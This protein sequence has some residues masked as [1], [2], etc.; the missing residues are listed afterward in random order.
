MVADRP[1]GHGAFRQRR[2]RF[3][4]GKILRYVSMV[5]WNRNA[6]LAAVFVCV[7]FGLSPFELFILSLFYICLYE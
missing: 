4:K 2:Q 6:P 3:I 1:V 5:C 7:P